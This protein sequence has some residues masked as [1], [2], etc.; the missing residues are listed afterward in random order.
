MNSET[1]LFPKRKCRKGKENCWCILSKP[2]FLHSRFNKIYRVVSINGIYKLIC[3]S[4]G[5]RNDECN[6]K[7][8]NC[9]IK[10]SRKHFTHHCMVNCKDKCSRVTFS[11]NDRTLFHVCKE[12]AYRVP[13]LQAIINCKPSDYGIY[14]IHDTPISSPRNICVVMAIA[15]GWNPGTTWYE[16]QRK[17]IDQYF[18]QI[19]A[20]KLFDIVVPKSQII[21]KNKEKI[22]Y[23]VLCCMYSG[24]NV[25]GYN[26]KIE[27]ANL[28]VDSYRHYF[29]LHAHKKI[30]DDESYDDNSYDD[31]D[32]YENYHEYSCNRCLD[33]GC[34]RCPDQ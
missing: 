15:C 25:G 24:V 32:D 27:E 17:N 12:S 23:F 13:Y 2:L 5:F 4:C 9:Y 29:N 1:T 34:H 3:K 8:I 28:R 30:R 21:T 31:D 14:Y 33:V 11:L 10:F 16:C 19:N 26:N 6:Q 22:S 18:Y 7:C 20:D